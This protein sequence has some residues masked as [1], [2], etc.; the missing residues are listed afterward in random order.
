MG[1]GVVIALAA[2]LAFAAFAALVCGCATTGLYTTPDTLEPGRI[3]GVALLEAWRIERS[4]PPSPNSLFGARHEQ[5]EGIAI[6]PTAM[7]RFGVLDGVEL[8]A[9]ILRADAKVRLFRQGIVTVAVDP[10]V[11]LVDYQELLGEVAEVPLLV[12][13]H[14]GDRV[15]VVANGGLSYLDLPVQTSLHSGN[16]SQ[17]NLAI[18]S[19]LGVRFRLGRAR[20]AL[21][22]EVAYLR[23][24]IG[25]SLDSWTGGLALAFGDLP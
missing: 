23:S 18:R 17:D 15:V 7:V 9:G 24:I 2:L 10:I 11:R 14:L 4:V 19:G 13:V 5:A 20:I 3:Q 22:P 12:G 25:G 16:P 8:S 6:I 21:Q 1:R